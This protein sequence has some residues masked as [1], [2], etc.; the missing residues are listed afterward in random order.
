MFAEALAADEL[1]THEVHG[2][3]LADKFRAKSPQILLKI[4]R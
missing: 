2:L 3:S 4:P 1:I